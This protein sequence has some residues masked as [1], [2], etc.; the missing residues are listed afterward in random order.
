MSQDIKARPVLW[1]PHVD[2]PSNTE[3]PHKNDIKDLLRLSIRLLLRPLSGAVG[4]QRPV[5]LRTMTASVPYICDEAPCE[6][7]EAET[8]RYRRRSVVLTETQQ[9]NLPTLPRLTPVR[10]CRTAL[11]RVAN[12]FVLPARRPFTPLPLPIDPKSLSTA[13]IPV[14]VY[15]SPIALP[16]PNG[17]A[18]TV[19]TTS[20][21]RSLPDPALCPGW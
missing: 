16:I 2:S 11:R 15:T 21:R 14:T 13:E 8:P 7:P 3:T 19:S 12:A 18:P 6:E 9:L 20:R 10:A 5:L 1:A 17:P 4:L